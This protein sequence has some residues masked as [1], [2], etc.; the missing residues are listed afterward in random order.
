MRKTIRAGDY[1]FEILDKDDSLLSF[2]DLPSAIAFLRRFKA[3]PHHMALMRDTVAAHFST[4]NPLNTEEL[5]SKMAELLVRGQVKILRTFE[6]QAGRAGEETEQPAGQGGQG[7]Q[8]VEKSWI[9]I[10]LRDM[11]GQPIPGKKYRIKLP[12]GT[13]EEGTLD[14]A[15]HAER[16]GI[17][18]GTCQVCFPEYDSESWE[19]ISGP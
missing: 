18:K 11:E 3:E 19:R 9:E 1:R 6:V 7:R 16:Y 13:I 10:Y 8:P 5:I 12:E 4:T 15:G 2:R 14:S 17:N